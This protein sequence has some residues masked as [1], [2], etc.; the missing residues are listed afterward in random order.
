[1]S[2]DISPEDGGEGLSGVD[3]GGGEGGRGCELA[4][5]GQDG[6]YHGLS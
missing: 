2:G 5:D 1:M 4:N 3:V 6:D